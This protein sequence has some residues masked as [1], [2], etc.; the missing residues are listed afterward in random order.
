MKDP[1][2]P[3]ITPLLSKLDEAFDRLEEILEG[4]KGL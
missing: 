2:A 4:R 1:P 3:E